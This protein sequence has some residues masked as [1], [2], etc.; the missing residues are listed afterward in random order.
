M[1][2]VESCNEGFKWHSIEP[3]PTK[4]VFLTPVEAGGL[5]YVLGGCDA[6]GIPLNDF[7]VW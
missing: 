1:A 6:K 5:L 2:E 4:R 7:Q 3:M